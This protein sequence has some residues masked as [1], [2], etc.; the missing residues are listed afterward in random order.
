MS[1]SYQEIKSYSVRLSESLENK[2]LKQTFDTLAGLL[3]ETQNW[4]LREQLSQLE[5]NYRMMLRYMAD[6]VKDPNQAKIYCGILRAVYEI[7][8]LAVSD[9]KAQSGWSVAYDYRK[10]LNRYYP[11]SAQQLIHEH[12]EQ[13]LFGVLRSANLWDAGEQRTWADYLADDIYPVSG[14]CLAVTALTLNLEEL[15][16]ERKI[17]LLLEASE[18]IYQEIRQR[19]IT[20]LLLALRRYDRRLYLYPA[21]E[22]R[23]EHLAENPGFV[24]DLR[25]I[26]LQFILSRETEKVSQIMK[27]EIIPGMMKISPVLNDRKRM[28]DIF[29]ETGIDEKNPEWQDLIE[30][31][32]LSERIKEFSEMQME[33]V[34]V[35]HS[36]FLHLK[37]FPFFNEMQNWFTL[38]DKNSKAFEEKKLGRFTDMLAESSMLC[39]S[40]KY[41]FFF[42]I[43]KM[44]E[45]FRE[46]IISRFS[47]ETE[48]I[49]DMMKEELQSSENHKRAHPAARQYIQDLYRFYKL[50]P[51]RA[52]IEDIF[53]AKPEFYR[54]PSISRFIAGTDSL[55]LIGE[56]YFNRNY[57]EEADDIFTRL[58]DAGRHDETLLQ[59]RGYCRQMLGNLQAALDDYLKA[60]LFN[61]NNPWTNKKIAYCYRALKQPGEALTYYL[62][63]ERLTPGNL[64]LETSIGHCL[65][66]MHR[67]DEALQ[68]YFKVEYLSG[69]NE[70]AWRPIAWSSFLCGKYEQAMDYYQ[71]IINAGPTATD[72]LNAGHTCLA[73]GNNR[74]AFRHYT[75]SISLHGGS[76]EKFLESFT[77]DIPYLVR[78]GVAEEDIP[79]IL[80]CLMY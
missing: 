36:S 59:K 41:S 42:S 12:D 31:A 24:R 10:N 53:N 20:G 40:D 33:G 64:S 15:F 77:V 29:S 72:C 4:Q 46:M 6:G 73:A 37:N 71:K 79:A 32:G 13:K 5:D 60:D 11:E 74:E 70:K 61:E 49:S 35:M 58:L 44:P 22:T 25:N 3:T 69:S 67:Y 2:R 9:L 34:D 47:S 27:D 30:E 57:F 56:H 23:L 39:N 38:F 16:D 76:H 65:L 63:A 8:D 75:S 66:E 43:D 14:R 26:I 7:A 80:D 19:A 51:R 48:S 68:R 45:T 52:N 62:K 21:I 17:D 55:P 18:N 50:Y 78:A 54:V 28:E 1:F